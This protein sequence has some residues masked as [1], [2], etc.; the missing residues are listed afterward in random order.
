MR[1]AV[2]LATGFLLALPIAAGPAFAAFSQDS[3]PP[4]AGAQAIQ[5]LHSADL[6][7]G[8]YALG[9]KGVEFSVSAERKAG[10][11]EMA[12]AMRTAGMLDWAMSFT[13]QGQVEA[14][15]E[16]GTLRP[17]RYDIQSDGSWSKRMTR[18]RWGDDGLPVAEVS[19]PNTEDDRDE[20]PDH[21]KLGTVDPT[22]AIFARAL[23]EGAEP[24]CT[25]SDAVYDGRRRYNLHYA[26]IGP[27][28]VEPHNR[29]AYSGPAFKCV[30]RS[31]PIAGYDRKYL[32]SWSEKDQQPTYIWLVQP[33]GFSVWL[34]VQMEGGFRLGSARGWIS[35]AKLNGRDWLAPLGFIRAEMPQ[36]PPP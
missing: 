21:L 35:R 26:P 19:P 15:F 25:G 14:R 23:R 4:T 34:P 17:V 33:P 3:D 16:D 11:L 2:S 31:E 5:R 22:T 29:T 12:T 8:V 6:S 20:V 10:R 30:I 18:M 36:L 7:F 24:P 32:A 13:M 27:D 9:S 1:H 28:M